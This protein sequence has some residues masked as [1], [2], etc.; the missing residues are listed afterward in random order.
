MKKKFLVLLGMMMTLLI[1]ACS[2][3]TAQNSS[4]SAAAPS[5][6]EVPAVSANTESTINESA[7]GHKILVAYFSRSGNTRELANIIQQ[8]TGGDLFEIVPQDPYPTDYNQTVERF[9]RERAE[10]A[11][12]A[13]ADEVDNMADYDVVFVGYP[14]WGSDMPHVVRTFLEQYDFSGKTVIPFCTNGGGG[15]GNSLETLKELCPDSDVLEGYQVNGRSVSSS[16]DAVAQWIN[17]LGLQNK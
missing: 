7:G 9:R 1:T 2:S 6:S 17:G 10:N 8:Q 3:G 13:I 14:N 4:S 5:S 12:P 15:F 16:S 11:R